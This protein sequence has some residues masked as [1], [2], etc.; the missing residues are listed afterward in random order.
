[1]ATENNQIVTAI[2]GGAIIA[3]IIYGRSHNKGFWAT[4]GIAVL[5]GFV[6]YVGA[7]IL[8]ENTK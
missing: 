1:V 4:F 8:E 5:F 6:G 3:G 7:S 2:T